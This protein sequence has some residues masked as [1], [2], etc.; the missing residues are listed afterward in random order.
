VS[1]AL[2]TLAAKTLPVRIRDRYREQWLADVRDAP[3]AG[4]RPATIA[5]AA[6]A[7]AV[8]LDR[9][10]PARRVPTASDRARRSRLAVGLAL[11]AASLSLTN[12]PGVSFGGLTGV[13]IYDFG[14]F[15]V[16]ALL[17]IYAVL[18]PVAALVLVRGGMRLPVVLLVLAS[19]ATIVKMLVDSSLAW[20]SV[21]ATPGALAYLVGGLLVIVACGIVWRPTAARSRWAP[22]LG[23][24][25]VWALTALALV[26]AVAAWAART[27]LVWGPLADAAYYQEWLDL[28]AG[29]EALVLQVF[30]V[31]A[32]V[33]LALGILVFV[34]GRFMNER[35]ATALGVVFGAIML[36]G[37]SG[38]LGFLELGMSDTVAPVLLDPLRLFAQA[39]L[40]AVTLVAVAGVRYLPR[41]GHRHDVERRVELIEG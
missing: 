2:V 22:V 36:L 25:A 37:A 40:T 32:F 14:V 9:P 7:F 1:T 26:Y 39:L 13:E 27:P 3:E 23:A 11:S 5:L 15:L 24:L 28:K 8:Q 21:Y 4:I 33:G 29:F 31:A 19:T 18:A 30:W 20:G 41:A 34:V 12:Y 16:T 17:M 35:R 6:L 10:F 38:V